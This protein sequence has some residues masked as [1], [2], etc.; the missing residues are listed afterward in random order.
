LNNKEEIS[1]T[2]EVIAHQKSEF[3]IKV[4]SEIYYINEN[5]PLEL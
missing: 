5:K 2:E 3:E 1:S 4:L